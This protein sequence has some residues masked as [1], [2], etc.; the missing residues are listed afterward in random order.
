MAFKF[1]VGD[2]VRLKSLEEIM[3]T[4]EFT[5][6]GSDVDYKNH[7]E[8]L[9]LSHEVQYCGEEFTVVDAHDYGNENRLKLEALGNGFI[10]RNISPIAVTMLTEPTRLFGLQG[11]VRALQE[12]MYDVA[13]FESNEVVGLYINAHGEFKKAIVHEDSEGYHVTYTEQPFYMHE[14]YIFANEWELI[15]DNNKRELERKM[16]LE[17]A[18]NKVKEALNE[19]CII[20]ESHTTYRN[21]KLLEYVD[22]IMR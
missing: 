15:V 1:K 17:E 12:G 3:A 2:K 18:K 14:D 4:G 16:K 11:S 6:C 10:L 9:L 7:D 20:S 13:K 8:I 21:L 19:L 5:K 22:S